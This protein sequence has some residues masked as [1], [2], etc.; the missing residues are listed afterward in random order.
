MIILLNGSQ[1]IVGIEPCRQNGRVYTRYEAYEYGQD[2][3][4]YRQFEAHGNGSGWV[5]SKKSNPDLGRSQTHQVSE[6]TG[7]TGEDP[8]FNEN[9]L[10]DMTLPKSDGPKD[11]DLRPALSDA[12]HHLRDCRWIG[13]DLATRANDSPSALGIAAELYQ[14]YPLYIGGT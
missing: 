11:P 6:D 1:G 7:Q 14:E 12:A 10:D 5:F 2:K 3:G 9:D 8:G 13:L 4:A